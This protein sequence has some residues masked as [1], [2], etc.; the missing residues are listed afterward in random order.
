[1]SPAWFSL[2]AGITVGLVLF[3]LLAADLLSGGGAFGI[4]AI[5]ATLNAL[6]TSFRVAAEV[7]RPRGEGG[8]E[9]ARAG[10]W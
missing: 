4:F 1:M 6:A 5:A 8:A 7:K 3:S 10:G 9:S 2:T